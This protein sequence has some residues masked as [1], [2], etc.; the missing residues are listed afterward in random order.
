M[1]KPEGDLNSAQIL[2]KQNMMQT[3]NHHQA[4]LLTSKVHH[5]L[6]V[7]DLRNAVRA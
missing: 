3:A 1:T 2:R 7:P 5:N 6:N 4:K